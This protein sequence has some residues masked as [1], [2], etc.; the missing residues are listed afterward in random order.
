MSRAKDVYETHVKCLTP[1]QQLELAKLISLN[2]PMPS[3]GATKL[4]DKQNEQPLSAR[5][6]QRLA[7]RKVF[8]DLVGCA[9]S[10]SEPTWALMPLPRWRVPYRLFDGTLLRVVEVDAYTKEVHLTPEEREELLQQLERL[11]TSGNA[12]A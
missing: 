2:V 3:S 8:G 1:D 6:A 9:L 10:S 7:D 11:V 4:D 5:A 12:P